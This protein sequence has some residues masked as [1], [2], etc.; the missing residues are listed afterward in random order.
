MALVR[1]QRSA[2]QSASIPAPV[3]GINTVS[4]GL[5][6]PPSDSIM[7]YNMIGG[8]YGLRSRIGWREYAKGLGEQVRS[9]LPFTGSV[10]SGAN[11]RLFCSTTSGIWD[12]SSGGIRIG[13]ILQSATVVAGGTSSPV[14]WYFVV[15]AVWGTPGG[16]VIQSAVSNELSATPAINE[17]VELVWTAAPGTPDYYF[18]YKGTVSGTYTRYHSVTGDLLTATVDAS[19]A[20]LDNYGVTDPSLS[21]T[22]AS[23][24]ADSGWGVSTVF[25][26]SGGD[27]Y[28][29]YCD[30]ENGYHVYSETGGT[31]EKVR[32]TATVAWVNATVYAAGATVLSGG[33]SYYTVA[34]GTSNGTS[35]ADDVGVTWVL[36]TGVGGVN[37]NNL[38][39]VMEW[40]NRLWFVEKDTASGWY[41]DLGAIKGPATEFN[42]GTQFRAGG[43]LRCLA[44]WTGDAGAGI[45]DALVGVSGGGD[46]LVYQGTDPNI[47]GAFSLRGVWSVGAVPLGRTLTTTS[48]GD[49]L[50]MGSTG[51]QSM[52]VL[53][54]SGSDVPTQYATAKI[55]NIW[56]QVQAST[57]T[58]RGWSMVIHPEEAALMVLIPE[59]AVGQSQQLVMSLITKGWH[60]FRATPMGVCAASW[61]GKLYF[62][63]DDGRICV[64]DGDVDGVTLNDPSSYSEIEWSVL[65]GFSNLG[66][67]TQ[68]RIHFIRP[69]LLSQGGGVPYDVVARFRWDLRE[70]NSVLGASTS[71]SSAWDSGLW[72]QAIWGGG[73]ISQQGTFGA[74]GMGPEVAIAIRGKS[75]ART[76]L[77]GIDVGYSEG[78]FL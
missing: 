55:A 22:F 19:G 45:D 40:K 21:L 6:L 1:T 17:S 29:C 72:D 60:Q 14:T 39:F 68:K 64:M 41:L 77:V 66:R 30:E 28:L 58:S 38:A 69:T 74:A 9:L 71:G 10:K 62:G 50:V 25:V 70:I 13:N 51:I 2:L 5:N 67:P 61:G 31:W 54:R 73:I 16:N 33:S 65:T 59:A 43:D 36:Y 63:T 7:S 32:Q 49:L 3:G 56:A 24:T 18:I 8:Q 4:P 20:T 47:A 26:N 11:D 76:T 12:V 35:V 44:N 23:S 75:A 15:V 27:H 57:R 42:F 78:G 53:V 48:G 37:P 52:S 34:G 46:V